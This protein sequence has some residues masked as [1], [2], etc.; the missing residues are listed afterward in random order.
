VVPGYPLITST[1][2][3]LPTSAVI[4]P[5]AFQV[6]PGDAPP[7]V[8]APGTMNILLLGS[9]NAV[10]ERYSRTD[11]ILVASVNPDMPSVSL[12]S[13]PRDLQ[14][15]I[16]NHAD[17]RINT[18]YEYGYMANYPGGGP[19]FLA[20]VLRKNFGLRIDHYVRIDFAGFVHVVDRLGG[21]QVVAECELH[22][23]FPDP[24]SVLNG[25]RMRGTVNLDVYPGRV[26]L[27]GYS[28]LMYARS[29]EST[30]DFDRARRQQKVL[31]SL[32]GKLKGSNLLANAVPLY[33]EF[34][35][36]IDTDLGLAS[37]PAFVDIATRL[38]NLAIKN[39]VITYPV[40]KNF[41][42]QDGA[43]VLLPTDTII[44]YIRDSLSP[45]AGNRAQNR[46][47]VEVVNASGR[48]D[49]E[50]VAADRLTWEGFSVIAASV[51]PSVQANT[52]I[53]DLTSSAKG[54]PIPRLASI[55]NV[56]RAFIT[57]QPDPGAPAAARVVLG[58]DYNS[59]P[60]TASI[61]GDV[62]LAPGTNLI[63]T[64]TPQQPTR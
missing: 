57:P 41:L 8:Q 33:E 50:A 64:S 14:V 45:P 55:F 13:I 20:L 53:D 10:D 40:V 16:P 2:G 25:T 60:P 26:Q 49:M 22:D 43:M 1:V 6:A 24:S 56:R 32:F 61:A 62:T 38:D 47:N 27:D 34:Q 23:T 44:P 4:D 18:A 36:N 11:T 37:M 3:P 17:D 48:K 9:D 46:I 31:R 19:A 42:R 52:T 29:R 35:R 21:V 30:T 51:S 28:A 15:R 5:N 58:K 59:C 39:R 7:L 12:L 54:S 63:P